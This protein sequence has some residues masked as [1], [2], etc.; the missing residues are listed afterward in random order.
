[1]IAG[2]FT[3]RSLG[4]VLL[5]SAALA[6]PTAAPITLARFTDSAAPTAAWS[7]ASLSPPTSLAAT[8][9]ATAGLTWTATVSTGAAGYNVLRSTTSGSG[10]SQITT[11]TPRTA[12]SYTDSPSTDA[13]YYYVLQAYVSNWTSANSNQASSV[14]H[15][16]VTGFRPC[17]SQGSDTG[18]DANGYELNPANGCVADGAV[19]TD[20]NSG[21]NTAVACGG[22]GKDRHR[23]W[24]FG[25][26]LPASVTAIKGITVK[27][28]SA[29]SAVAGTNNVC[30]ELSWNAGTTWTAAQQVS[31][32]STAL[33]FYT[34]G[35]SSSLWARAWVASDFS[36]ANFRVRLTDVANSTA[37]TFT[38]DSVQVQ[39]DYTP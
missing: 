17:G 25:L 28:K 35:G 33:T 36:D 34:L 30:A 21:T 14:I 15:M 27:V 12:T 31:L 11:V 19:A 39:V 6:S 23:F 18:G 16:G 38:L 5:I 24:T 26:G 32:T 4:V 8:S 2:T 1:M 22:A 3:M 20:A 37:R 9:G 7:T 29:I 13:T 10:Y